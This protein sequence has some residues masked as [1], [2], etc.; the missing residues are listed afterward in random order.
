S[1]RFTTCCWPISRKGMPKNASK[2]YKQPSARKKN[3]SCKTVKAIWLSAATI[4]IPSYGSFIKVIALHYIKFF[5]PSH[6]VPHRRIRRKR[7]PCLSFSPS[8]VQNKNG[9]PG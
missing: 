3:K 1:Q 4:T 2:P 6:F 5:V 9:F 7:R 8:N